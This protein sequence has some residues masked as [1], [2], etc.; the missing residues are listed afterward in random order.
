[1]ENHKKRLNIL[2]WKTSIISNVRLLPPFLVYILYNIK[3]DF[4]KPNNK[5]ED[6]MKSKN[7]KKEFLV[8]LMPTPQPIINLQVL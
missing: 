7:Q 1:M 8:I 2:S 4:F 5:R 6:I 3:H